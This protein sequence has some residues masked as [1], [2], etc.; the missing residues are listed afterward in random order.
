MSERIYVSNGDD[1]KILNVEAQSFDDLL[2]NG[3]IAVGWG[4]CEVAK[5]DKS[6]GSHV[7][8]LNGAPVPIP[9]QSKPKKPVK[10]TFKM[11][12]CPV[13][14]CKQPGKGPRYKWFCAEH[15]DM[16]KRELAKLMK[17]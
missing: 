10:S 7:L 3:G 1:S 6:K 15:R 13:P 14:K 17:G 12:P 16:P 11:K 2:M 9:A 8:T 4:E 5:K